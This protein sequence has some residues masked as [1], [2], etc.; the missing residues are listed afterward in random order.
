MYVLDRHLNPVPDGVAGELSI[1]G[2]GLARGYRGRAGLTAERFVADPFGSDGSRLYRT[3]DLVRRRADGQLEFL[4]RVDEQV[5]VRGFRIEAGEVEA[6]LAAHPGVGAAVVAAFG[7]DGGKRLVAYLVPADPEAG[8]PSIGELRAF[9]GQRLPEYMVPAVF[10]ELSEIPRTPN[11][12]VDRNALPTPEGIRPDSAA[13]FTAPST[14]AE[15]LLAGIWAEVLGLDRVGVTDDFFDLGGHSLLATRVVSRIRAVFDVEIPL[16]ALFDEPTVSGLAGV[17]DAASRLG[18]AAPPPITPVDRAGRPVP[19]SFAQQRLWFLDRLEPGS[20]DYNLPMP[21]RLTGALNVAALRAALDALVVRHE[22]LRTRLVADADGV[23]NQ[24]VD[25]AIGFDLPLLDL[26]AEADPLVA[27]DDSVAADAVTP[28]DLATGPLIRGTLMHLGPDDHVL[29]LCLHHVVADEWS[30]G[31]LRRELADH[32]EAFRE[33]QPSPLAPLT[34]QYAD[35]AMWQREW[36]SGSVLDRQLGYW[37]ERLAGAPVLELP[38]DR[39]RPAVRSSAGA[40]VEFQVPASTAEGLHRVARDSGATMFM[41]L[42][43]GFTVLLSRYA[44][45][46]DI[47]VGTPVANRNR[48]ETEDLIGFFV[49][50]L[51][52]RADLHGDP[53]FAELLARV[54]AVSL[55]AYD[56]QDLPFEQ[57]VEALQPERDRSRSALFQVMFDYGADR[58]ADLGLGGLEVTAFGTESEVSKFDLTVGLAESGDG[59]L[60]GSVKYS[61]ALFDASRMERLAG[62]LLMLLEAVAGD[63]ELRLS[64]LPVLTA[65]EHRSLTRWNATDE[66]LPSVGGVHDVI[67]GQA[68]RC[69]DQVAVECGGDVVTYA[70]LDLRAN[71]LAW[72]LRGLGVGAESVVGLCVGRGVDLVVA[73][74]AVWKA[75][76]AFLPL[77]AD[78]PVDRLSFMLADS[79]LSLLVGHRSIVPD[80]VAEQVSATV[81]LDD[82]EVVARIAAEPSAAL[83]A[84]TSPD[85]AAYVIYTSGSTGRPKGVVVSQGSLVNLLGSMAARP[86]LSSGD[87]AVAVTTFGFDIAGL[88]L[89]GPLTVGARL[90]V[91]ES[92]QVVPSLLAATGA[93]WVQGTPSTWRM[94]LDDGW[95]PSPGLRVLC[96]GEAL[97]SNL[98]DDLVGAGVQLW[99]MY[100]PTETTIWSSCAEVR[101]GDLV[102]L[103][104]PIANTRLHVLDRHLNPVP[105]GV[106]GELYIAGSG[107]ARGYLNRPGL[108][109]ERFVPDPS[110]DDGSRMYRTGDLV[111]R[112]ADG[113]LEFL[114]RVDEQVKVRGFRIEPGEIEAALTSH[115]GVSAA[116]VVAHGGAD[117]RRLVAFLVPADAG[118]GIPAVSELRDFAG[119][120]L[121]EYMIPAVFVEL[122]EIPRT[123]NGKVDRKALPNVDGIRLEPSDA[124][125][126][127][128]TPTEELLAGIWAGVLGLDRVGVTDDFFD[129]G[130]HS[131]LA[132]R[133]VSRIRAVLDVEIPLAALFDQPTVAGLAAV[134][135][136]SGSLSAASPITPSDRDGRLLPLSFAQQRLWFLDRLEPG[137]LDY[138]VPMPIRLI[139]ALDVAALHAALDELVARH[140]VLRTRLVADADG[141]AHQLIEP[142]TGFAL[143]ETDVTQAADPLAAAERV[144]AED[145]TR[146]FDLAAGPLI[147]G[148]LIR[149]APDD[150][151]LSLCSHHVIL[152]E[153]S[154]GILR[155]ELTAL[156]NAFH[157]GRPSPLPPLPVQ[158]AD[159]AAWQRDQL[160]GSVLDAQLGYW[161]DRLAGAPLLELPTDRPRPTVRTSAGGVV[162]YEVPDEVAER[163]REVSRQSG[164]TMFMTLFA[165]FTVLLSRYTGQDDIVVGTPIAN[166]N[167]AE[168]EDL[169]GFFVNTLVLRADLSGDP[170]FVDLV[171]RVRGVA[172]GAYAHQ[173]LPFEQLVDV[174]QPERDRSRTPLFQVMFNYDR[175]I[176]PDAPGLSG[177]EV[178]AVGGV[179]QD[180]TLFD[181]TLGVADSDDGLRGLFEFSVDL[182]DRST[183]ERIAKLWVELLAAVAAA[184]T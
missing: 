179:E 137:S 113:E 148:T 127:A 86:G 23:V 136:Q 145:V 111:S 160:T 96:G 140:E 60:S 125:T 50:T 89:F 82:P 181:L 171:G 134:V 30:V 102:S 64:E 38:S 174:L 32:Y 94:L 149:L 178:A 141:A 4:G 95:V 122:S 139:G 97:P 1:A 153:W 182:F 108:T 163:L 130:G 115:P 22:V 157:D 131:L 9:A 84:I 39:P 27:A 25:P 109:A 154:A 67:A 119:Q 63:A 71:R 13:V 172:L 33:G 128:S 161:R 110:A 68:L 159:F 65:D 114:G 14:P 133:V 176:A 47:M 103:G 26:S 104:H 48:A 51:V 6:V 152:D 15:E 58:A 107:L 62:H 92:P 106:V 142:A 123:P 184:L 138:N 5:K 100:G 156:Y 162:V 53:T 124:F 83:S 37:R 40:V 34:V 29:S 129:L 35:F 42:F 36:L 175:N 8:P 41:T 183:V 85:Q 72:H 45:Q 173:D 70:E 46:D 16:A 116:L 43:A 54:R 143:R 117:D 81:W 120:R 99:N 158:Y 20:L 24:L 151:I 79:G 74:L 28:F 118:V 80:S 59:G 18:F 150:H 75:G 44:G 31:I 78:Y 77:D 144:V 165:A 11:G 98:A 19:L 105:V 146:S 55:G 112:R 93:G 101:S 90:V 147:C 88:E 69:S 121:P 87:V 52:L 57:L 135:D 91:A 155:R 10:V 2:A 66:H 56:H 49:N 180:R 169:I 7:R 132:T 167:Q 17:V 126:P 21:I 170:A 166:R 61:T 12:K 3:G 164:A 73:C 177:L 76:G 168:T